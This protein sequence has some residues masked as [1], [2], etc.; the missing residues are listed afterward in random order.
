[1]SR[2]LTL[3]RALVLVLLLGTLPGAASSYLLSEQADNQ[4]R[5]NTVKQ[6]VAI[7]AGCERSNKI[8]DAVNEAV[9]VQATVN[10]ALAE[11]L[12]AARKARMMSGTRT[13]LAAAERYAELATKVA[14]VDFD[15]L[16]NPNCST[17]FPEPR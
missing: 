5:E 4:A 8:R 3:R 6:R 11:F 15:H 2:P 1:M 14:A 12:S 16:V 9:D 7:V 17:A 10:D 13:D